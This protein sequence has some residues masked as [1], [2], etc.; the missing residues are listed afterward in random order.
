MG[1][2]RAPALAD[3]YPMSESGDNRRWDRRQLRDRSAEPRLPFYEYNLAAQ[4]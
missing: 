3:R 4:E 1:I 2:A